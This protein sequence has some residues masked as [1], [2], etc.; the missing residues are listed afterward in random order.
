MLEAHTHAI[1][2]FQLIPL[3][4]NHRILEP[5]RSNHRVSQ[6]AYAIIRMSNYKSQISF[7]C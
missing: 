1:P 6:R 3:D 5:Y 4:W 7:K 2:S